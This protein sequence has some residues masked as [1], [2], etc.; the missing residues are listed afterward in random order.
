[1]VQEQL[2]QYID[3]HQDIMIE[4]LIKFVEIPSISN[5][6]EQVAIALKHIL[7]LGENMGFTTKNLLD[8]QIGFIEMGTGEEVFGI[9]SHVDV[10]GPGDESIWDIPPFRGTLKEGKIYGR[11]TLD[12]KGAIIA[13]MYAMQA[14][15]SLGLPLQKRVQLILGTQE[16]VEWTDMESYV[17]KFPL[18]DYG[19]TPDGSFPICN[20]EKGAMDIELI[21]PVNLPD[22][23][24]KHPSIQEITAGKALNVV[25]GECQISIMLPDGSHEKLQI[26]GR[27]VHSCQP[28]KGK[29]AIVL[30]GKK[31]KAL[32]NETVIHS[33][34][35]TDF[36]IMVGSRFDSVYGKALDLYSDNEYYNGEFVHRNT[37]SP[38]LA[39]TKN[40]YLHMSFNIR[41]P[42]GSQEE[43]LLQAFKK[44][45]EEFNGRLGQTHR[46]PAVYVNKDRPFLK[47]FAQAYEKV[48]QV[49]NEFTL[50]YGGTY[51]K[52]IPNVVSWGPIFPGEEDTC[53]EE[54]EYISV[55]GLVNNAKIFALAISS[56]VLSEKSFR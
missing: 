42:Y 47:I 30:M 22:T 55:K 38:T 46:M 29:N 18:P 26:L 48:T 28:E 23:V 21:I 15:L 51:A 44:L 39:Y 6:R 20:I 41:F 11:G 8:D 52:A 49:P 12:D 9:L 3:M 56:I 27:S 4:E 40:G 13:V 37:F 34:N 25:P 43:Y 53:H 17:N 36:L 10:V 31:I 33:N 24:A 14:V 1:M 35:I 2:L 16:E 54:N 45:A 19:F 50:E 32:L 7:A 5:E